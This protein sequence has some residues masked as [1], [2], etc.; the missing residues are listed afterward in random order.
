MIGEYMN[1][2]SF[3]VDRIATALES[4]GLIKEAYALDVIANTLDAAL[5]L[6]TAP[7][8]ARV[9]AQYQNDEGFSDAVMA[10]KDPNKEQ[11]VKNA[12]VKTWGDEWGM[13]LFNTAKQQ[14]TAGQTASLLPQWKQ[15]VMLAK[16]ALRRTQVLQPSYQEDDVF[17]PR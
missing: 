6:Q 3:Y 13:K 1:R 12:L 11:I 9:R 17:L 4:R 16:N 8:R 2:L 15:I 7:E 14:V 5:D 10:L